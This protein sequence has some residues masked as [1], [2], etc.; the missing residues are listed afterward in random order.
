MV[1]DANFFWPTIT[2]ADKKDE[3]IDTTTIPVP[4]LELVGSLFEILKIALV[5]ER[6]V[7][8][9]VDL[10]IWENARRKIQAFSSKMHGVSIGMTHRSSRT[11]CLKIMSCFQADTILEP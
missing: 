11:G 9:G 2:D 10:W 8:V 6:F 5:I 7:R 1:F 4:L 3:Q